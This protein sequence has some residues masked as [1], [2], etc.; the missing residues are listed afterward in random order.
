MNFNRRRLALELDNVPAG[1]IT[2][3]ALKPTSTEEIIFETGFKASMYVSLVNQEHGLD[4]FD[5]RTLAS[6]LKQMVPVYWKF[7]FPV[8]RFLMSQVTEDRLEELNYSAKRESGES[9]SEGENGIAPSLEGVPCEG[10]SRVQT[11]SGTVARKR[12]IKR[13]KKVHIIVAHSRTQMFY[14]NILLFF[15]IEFSR[16]S[17]GE[18]P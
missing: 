13:S 9:V 3:E 2:C 16:N 4:K 17:R 6:L 1:I 14:L 12:L 7:K 18:I 11:N 5:L 15:R 10:A 8:S